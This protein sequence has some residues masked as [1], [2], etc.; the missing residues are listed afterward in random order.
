MKYTL[1]PNRFYSR[2]L[3]KIVNKN[4]KILRQIDKAHTLLSQNPKDAKLKSHKVISKIAGP[5]YSS[6][7]N[8]DLRIIWDYSENEIRVL[9]LLDIGGHSGSEGVY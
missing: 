8:S 9:D 6:S 7:V 4:P 1:T 2:K 5:A 3:Q